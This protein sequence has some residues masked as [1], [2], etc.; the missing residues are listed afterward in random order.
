MDGRVVAKSAAVRGIEA[1]HSPGVVLDSE[2]AVAI[3][4]H[5]EHLTALSTKPLQHD[6]RDS[7]RRRFNSDANPRSFLQGRDI[8]RIKQELADSRK[9]NEGVKHGYFAAD[10]D[11]PE[12][13]VA[14]AI[15]DFAE[16]Y[17]GGDLDM[18]LGRVRIAGNLDIGLLVYDGEDPY[19]FKRVVSRNFRTTQ[20]PDGKLLAGVSTTTDADG[21]LVRSG[22]LHGLRHIETPI[23]VRTTEQGRLALVKV[24]DALRR[25][26][27]AGLQAATLSDGSLS[28]EESKTMREMFGALRLGVETEGWL[29]DEKGNPWQPKTD[30][31]RE[32][33]EGFLVEFHRFMAEVDE[34]HEGVS[35]I[36]ASPAQVLRNLAKAYI[37]VNSKLPAGVRFVTTSV[38]MTGNPE[39]FELNDHGDAGQYLSVLRQYLHR[40]FKVRGELSPQIREAVA[41]HWGCK[42]PTVDPVLVDDIQKCWTVAARQDSVG[43]INVWSEERQCFVV[44]DKELFSLSHALLGEFGALAQ[45]MAISGAFFTGVPVKF[46]DPAGGDDLYAYGARIFTRPDPGSAGSFNKHITGEEDLM[47]RIIAG[48]ISGKHSADRLDRVVVSTAVTEEDALLFEGD[49]QYRVDENGVRHELKFVH[50]DS[51][52]N[53]YFSDNDEQIFCWDGSNL[54]NSGR[55]NLISFRVTA[56]GAARFR[57]ARI[58]DKFGNPVPSGRIEVTSPDTSDALAGHYSASTY[59][60]LDF[61]SLLALS[62]GSNYFGYVSEKTGMTK[63][64]IEGNPDALVMAYS[65]YG[66]T[67]PEVVSAVGRARKI[68]SLI[69]EK[70]FPA[71]AQT[72][73]VVSRALD[74]L[75]ADNSFD[76]YARTGMGTMGAAMRRLAILGYS[77]EQASQIVARFLALQA[78][79]LKNISDEDVTAGDVGFEFKVGDVDSS[80]SGQRD[81]HQQDDGDQPS[82]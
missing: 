82:A 62:G 26:D 11:G 56:H 43:A 51:Y 52:G 35:G 42:N 19:H 33:L 18:A 55:G 73:I 74:A 7:L 9:R 76:D 39:T 63:Q 16:E 77:A 75:L 4:P 67:A 5:A 59:Q 60:A 66:P 61:L 32:G 38:P 48:T 31:E 46:K 47:M 23:L 30:V 10:T 34:T 40:T 20:D 1:L 78:E 81:G 6:A 25:L 14:H 58:Y 65:L 49:H 8:S 44:G 29:V 72:K 50:F 69:D 28:F 27:P 37:A 21:N 41:L 79:K 13:T 12:A 36:Q 68:L 22:A 71:L 17:F 57:I 3:K 53:Y 64:E 24:M 70:E 45:I 2:R 15:V 80:S 54:S